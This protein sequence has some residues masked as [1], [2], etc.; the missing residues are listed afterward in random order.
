MR[1]SAITPLIS[2]RAAILGFAAAAV[3]P[4]GSWRRGSEIADPRCRGLF[5]APGAIPPSRLQPFERGD[6]LLGATLL[7]S[8]VDAYAGR[9]RILQLDSRLRLK[10]SLW[11]VG[12]SHQLVSLEVG[13][14]GLLWAFDPTNHAVVHVDPSG[15]QRP[16][17]RFGERPFGSA[18]FGRDGRIYL[19]EY[20]SGGLAPPG[21]CFRFTPDGPSLGAG[22]IYEYDASWHRMQTLHNSMVDNAPFPLG[23][24]HLTLHPRLPV[25]AYAAAG[26]KHVQ[27]YDVAKGRRIDD[28]VAY[29]G[30]L[31]QDPR[32]AAIRYL[33]DGRLLLVHDEQ[34][35]IL[36]ERGEI[37]RE[38]SLKKRD[39]A[40]VAPTHEGT[41][42]LIANAR[43]GELIKVSLSTG[44][45]VAVFDGLASEARRAA[46]GV[47]EYWP[48]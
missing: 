48:G 19:G 40:A 39:W 14:Q 25:L 31:D 35:Q 2:R 4:H 42:C 18:A 5:E 47:I 9:G 37:E 12:T 38:W 36:D 46:T 3:D 7:N 22:A 17:F 41:H 28:L 6:I 11:T 1:S 45:I 33:P 44:A 20:F 30:F 26:G 24:T 32:V 8:A 16:Q 23:V 29:S 43:S 15:L 27:R 13:P 10:A 34:L 21:R